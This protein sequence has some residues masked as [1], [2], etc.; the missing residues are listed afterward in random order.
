VSY[1]WKDLGLSDSGHAVRDLWA[2]KDL[3]SAASLKTELPTHATRLY[4]VR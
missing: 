2:R 3:G 4:R 1:S